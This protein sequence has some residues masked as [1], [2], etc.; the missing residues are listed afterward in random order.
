LTKSKLLPTNGAPL[1]TLWMA[2]ALACNGVIGPLDNDKGN[3][4]IVIAAST[5]DGVDGSDAAIIV[6]LGLAFCLP[7]I[8]S[9]INTISLIVKQQSALNI[10][11]W[12]ESHS[13]DKRNGV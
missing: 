3:V 8:T 1:A 2:K 9:K 5:I 13:R 11:A 12:K 7:T 6:W 4:V 10:T